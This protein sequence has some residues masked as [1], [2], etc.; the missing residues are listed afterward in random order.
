M[1]C[2]RILFLSSCW[3]FCF[4]FFYFAGDRQVP[5]PFLSESH[6][7][8]KPRP[9]TLTR[10]LNPSLS[11]R[12]TSFD[13]GGAG[14]APPAVEG[15]GER[16]SAGEAEEANGA[17]GG[18]RSSSGVDEV[19]P[20]DAGGAPTSDGA[21]EEGQAEEG[22]EGVVEEGAHTGEVDSDLPGQID[23]VQTQPPAVETL[24]VGMR[25]VAAES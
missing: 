22:G 21:A 13:E 8:K 2:S 23:G 24:V 25:T 5:V 1:R 17:E 15:G 6:P 4:S 12:I 14:G 20:S 19:T 16:R 7:S 11:G 3:F 9:H 10:N 18:S